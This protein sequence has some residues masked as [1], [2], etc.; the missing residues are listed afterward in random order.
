MK[1]HGLGAIG[2]AKLGLGSN[3]CTVKFPI[4]FI[5]TLTFQLGF[6]QSNNTQLNSW[7]ASHYESCPLDTQVNTM[8]VLWIIL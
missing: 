4:D 8:G 2:Y 6:D 3:D 1:D 5:G 7:K